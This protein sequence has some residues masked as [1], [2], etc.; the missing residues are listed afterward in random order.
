MQLKLTKW[1][2]DGKF[3]EPHPCRGVLRRRLPKEIVLGCVG[4]DTA[5]TFSFCEKT[6][7]TPSAPT[8]ERVSIAVRRHQWEAVQA[9]PL[10]PHLAAVPCLRPIGTSLPTK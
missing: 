8:S 5:L 1:G 9:D 7:S 10:H 2:A 3:G 4:T 6:V